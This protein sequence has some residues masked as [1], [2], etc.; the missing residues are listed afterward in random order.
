MPT[1]PETQR[2]KMM[3]GELYEAHDPEL[4]ALRARARQI[5][6]AYN[7]TTEAERDV[8][9]ALLN[10]LLGRMAPK[11]EIEPP[12]RCDYGTNI[13]L[14]DGFYANFGV[15]MLD[16]AEIRI[17]DNVL[18]AP[19]V[20]IYTAHHPIDP[21]VRLTGRELASPVTIG[22]NVWIGGGA[23]VLPGVSIGDNTIIGAGSV[24]TRDVPANVVAAGNPCRVL[25]EL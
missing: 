16:C 21:E 25:R 24:V 15:V 8:R 19:N 12:F 14:G 22:N 3:A 13:F 6:R 2:Q 5:T 10:R 23:L 4:V 20:Q 1:Q 17:G 18:L 7:N 11:M 9:R